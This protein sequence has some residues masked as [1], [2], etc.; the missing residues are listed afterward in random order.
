MGWTRP[1]A[2]F[3]RAFASILLFARP[4]NLWR[5][6]VRLGA[7]FLQLRAAWNYGQPLFH[8]RHAVARAVDHRFIFF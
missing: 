2:D 8:A 5:D 6:R 1:S 4:Q 3:I 7:V